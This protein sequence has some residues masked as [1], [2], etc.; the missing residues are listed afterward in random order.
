M[1][2]LSELNEG[3]YLVVEPIGYDSILM[4][5]RE[6]VQS[7]W[8]LDEEKV[9]VSLAKEVYATFDLYY[10]LECIEDDMHEDWLGNVM[11]QIPNEVRDRIEK[12][13]NTYLEKEPTYYPGEEVDC[14]K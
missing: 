1:K 5:K 8:Y 14:L 3:T 2:N 9:K 10:A 11:S 12:E 13:I 7:N 4:D 6:F